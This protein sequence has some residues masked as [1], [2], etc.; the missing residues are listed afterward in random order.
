VKISVVSAL[1]KGKSYKRTFIK[2]TVKVEF[3]YHSKLLLLVDGRDIGIANE[4]D[5]KSSLCYRQF[6]GFK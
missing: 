1:D 5:K 6:V 4:K 3:Q 2:G